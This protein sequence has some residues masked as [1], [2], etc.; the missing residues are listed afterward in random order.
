MIFRSS[1]EV[2]IAYNSKVVG[3][4]TKIKVR[5]DGQMIETTTGQSIY[6]TRLFRKKWDSSISCLLRK[7]SAD[8]SARCL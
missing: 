5:I 7:H 6:L 4:H 3:L 2:I 1:D 8:L